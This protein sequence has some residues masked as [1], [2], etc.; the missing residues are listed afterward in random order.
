MLPPLIAEIERHT[1]SILDGSQTCRT[2]SCPTC[3]AE[4]GCFALHALRP[5]TFL[6]AVAAWVRQLASFVARY[7]C[8]V[9]GVT[10]TDYPSFAIPGKRYVVATVMSHAAAYL[11]DDEATYRSSVSTPET[12]AP[13]FYAASPDDAID[14]RALAPSTLWRWMAVLAAMKRT[15]AAAKRLIRE[16]TSRLLRSSRL[17]ARRKARTDRRRAILLGAA[18]LIATAAAYSAAFAG[19]SIFTESGTRRRSG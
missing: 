10:F 12:N 14:E 8:P 7:R 19:S 15:V 9:C 1:Q 13:T 4:C 17:V 18:D 3:R 6:V 16:A 2:E 5:R 11:G